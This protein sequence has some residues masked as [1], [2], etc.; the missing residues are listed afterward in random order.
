MALNLI[1]DSMMVL[2]NK[3]RVVSSHFRW[4]NTRPNVQDLD[5]NK[6]M[7]RN[8]SLKK[9]FFL[10]RYPLEIH[11]VHIKTGLTVEQAVERPDGIAVI[12]ILGQVCNIIILS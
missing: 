9:P 4:R 11:M 6:Q 5:L 10:C 1:V 2:N 3:S 7:I 8:G 12:G